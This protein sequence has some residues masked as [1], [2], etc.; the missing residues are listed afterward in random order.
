MT[1]D[2]AGSGGIWKAVVNSS[3]SKIAPA[4]IVEKDGHSANGVQKIKVPSADNLDAALCMI[5]PAL[6]AIPAGGPGLAT[7]AVCGGLVTYDGTAPAAGDECG[8]V[9]GSTKIKK[10]NTGFKAGGASGGRANIAPMGG[11]TLPLVA[12]VAAP[13]GGSVSVKF[14]NADGSLVGNAFSVKVLPY[15]PAP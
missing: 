1:A 4:S 3:A 12:T 6:C 7:E 9:S 2:T 13:S 15:E 8:T 10:S 11:S 5:T 14:A